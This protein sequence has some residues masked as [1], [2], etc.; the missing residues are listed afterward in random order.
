MGDQNS[1][2]RDEHEQLIGVE[3][4]VKHPQYKFPK[5]IFDL[6]MIRLQEPVVWSKYA[7][8]VCLPDVNRRTGRGLGY[9][10][11]WGYDAE[12]KRGGSPTEDLHLAKLPIIENEKCQEWFHSQGKKITLQPEH[13]CAGHERGQQDG[14]QGD[15]GGGLVSVDEEELV[16]VGVM[17]A[18]I[19]CGR[20]KLP[21]VY[22]RVEK[23]VSWV[24]SVVRESEVRSKREA[25]EDQGPSPLFSAF[26]KSL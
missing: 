16:L 6:A 26:S 24:E 3:E 21:G 11:G 4:I 2:D 17:S 14:C 23:F 18:G 7:Q 13:L 22:T 25:V 15:S 20:I 12:S 8:P 19:G 9:L 5:F 10:A 1:N